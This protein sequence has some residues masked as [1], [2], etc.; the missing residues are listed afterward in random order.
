MAVANAYAAAGAEVWNI[1]DIDT[2]PVVRALS[3]TAR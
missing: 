3:Q 2:V 1:A